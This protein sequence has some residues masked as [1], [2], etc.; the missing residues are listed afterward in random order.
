MASNST[1]TS[2][3]A[4]LEAQL[5]S[6]NN[7]VS[8]LRTLLTDINA[9]LQSALASNSTLSSEKAS[10]E[11]QLQTADN[12]ISEL[13]GEV[14]TLKLQ[15]STNFNSSNTTS[16]ST[17][18][19][20]SSSSTD[21]AVKKVASIKAYGLHTFLGVGSSPISGSF[22]YTTYDGRSSWPLN[23]SNTVSGEL[24]Q[25]SFGSTNFVTDYLA[26]NSME[27]TSTEQ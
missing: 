20:S 1:L 2:E 17:S 3:K 6:A 12:R 22:Y 11:T 15:Q 18:Q 14:T 24:K 10:L 16:G 4:S 7:D 13:E 19:S 25:L 23:D 27:F 26:G 8:S 5:A 9:S 21:V